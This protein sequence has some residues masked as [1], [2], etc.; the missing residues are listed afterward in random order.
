MSREWENR[1]YGNDRR[2]W[3]LVLL[4]LLLLVI[5]L[6]VSRSLR[7]GVAEKPLAPVGPAPPSRS[8]SLP[9]AAPPEP[10]P[11][12]AIAADGFETLPPAAAGDAAGKADDARQGAD[13]LFN[14]GDV[15]GALAAYRHLAPTD[16]LS[17]GRAGFCLARLGRWEEAVIELRE[18]ANLLPNDFA[19]RKLLTYA[20]YRQNDLEAASAQAQAALAIQAD[21]GLLD[22]QAKLGTEIR[23]QRHYDDARTGNFVVLFDGYEHDE[24]KRMVLDILKDAYA[25]IGKELDYFPEQPISVILYTAKDFSDV[26]SAPAWVSG[27]FGKFD[28]KIRLPVQ[29]ATGRERELRRVLYHE[30]TH[31]LLFLLAPACPLWLQEGLA[32]YFC[33]DR[34]VSAWQVIPLSLLA[35]GFPAEPSAAYAAY[36]ESL[37]AVSDLLEEHGMAR[38]HQLL[39]K[40]SEGS[41][42]ESAFATAFGQPFSHWAKNWRPAQSAE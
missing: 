30:Y 17:R 22:L 9:P 10:S 34:P 38:L 11:T 19:V 1:N 26:T 23:V 27:L 20:L 36:M 24:S 32:Q 25:D 28:G 18:A 40:L 8:R 33:G 35:R 4:A 39:R 14:S 37:Q 12:A 15:A 16:P 42:L 7:R 6:S 29:G 41:D 2:F 31:A 13:A 21:D 5:V 3:R